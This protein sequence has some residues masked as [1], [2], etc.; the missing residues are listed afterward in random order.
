MKLPLSGVRIVDLTVVWAGPFATMVRTDDLGAGV[1]KVENIHV[2]QPL[3][4]GIMARPTR[5]P[6]ANDA[7]LGRRLPERRPVGRPLEPLRHHAHFLPQ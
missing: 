4:R 3:T 7:F 1:V 2:W 5:R 6:A